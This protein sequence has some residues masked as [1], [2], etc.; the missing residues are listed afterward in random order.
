[1]IIKS[2]LKN[3]SNIPGWKTNRKIVVIESDDWGSIRMPSRKARKKLEALEVDMGH[4]AR[5]RFT[6]FDTLAN[7]DDLAS[8]YETLTKLKDVN[9]NSPVITAVSVVANPCFEKIKDSNFKKYFYEPFTTTLEKYNHNNTFKMWQE[10]VEDHLFVP[11]FHGREHLNVL[12]WMRQLLDKDPDT[13]AAFELQCWGYANKNKH[14]IDY[15][16]AYDLETSS[17]ISFQ[18]TVIKEGLE[19]FED[20]HKYKADFFV[21]PNGPFNNKL[22]T[23]AAQNGIKYMSASKIQSEPQGAGREKKVFH[24]LGQQNNNLQYY[25]TRN[26][27][28]EPSDKSKD[29]VN[30]CLAE[31]GN[32]FKWHKPAVISSHRVNYVG[33]LDYNNRTYGLKQLNTLLTE[34]QK[35]WPDVEFMTSS[36]LGQTIRGSKH[37]K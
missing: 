19:L 7:E 34:I 3:L 18:E 35:K 17:D 32:A 36:E 6:N 2:L 25:I 24:W 30:S 14:D 29:W 16:A 31:I 13:H 10:G 27:F 4:K 21:P 8:L 1:M 33:G 5:Q 37:A 9:G 22:E 11:Q 28:F 12:V 15:Q 20:I 26:C 23:I